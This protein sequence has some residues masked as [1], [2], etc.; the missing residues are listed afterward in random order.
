MRPAW[1]RHGIGWGLLTLIAALTACDR[2]QSTP[3]GGPT[4]QAYDR[5]SLPEAKPEY[6]FAA[7]LE[8]DFPEA[9]GFMRHLLET[10]LAGDYT[11]YRRL[12]SRAADP[13]SRNRF[14]KVLNSLKSL[15]ITSIEEIDSLQVPPPAYLVVGQTEFLPD[16]NVALRR[17]DVGGGIAILVF[18]EDGELRMTFAPAALQPVVAEEPADPGPETTSAPSYDQWQEDVDY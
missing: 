7:G 4:T 16:R 3:S 9:V 13:E 17:R 11:G 12:V 5:V 18:R 15:T 8:D 6:S 10:C 14:E 1:L 2:G